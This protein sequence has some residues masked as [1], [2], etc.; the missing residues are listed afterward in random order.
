MRQQ[1][2]IYLPDELY[3]RFKHESVRQGLSLSAYVTRQL[4]TTPSQLDQLQHWLASR[5]DR[6][7]AAL[8]TL[9]GRQEEP[10]PWNCHSRL[11]LRDGGGSG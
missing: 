11:R 6:L 10:A 9:A 1:V 3:E 4:A 5:L 2:T 8:G 7:D